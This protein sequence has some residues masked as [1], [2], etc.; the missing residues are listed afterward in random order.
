M[1]FVNVDRDTNAPRNYDS[2]AG[3]IL[4]ENKILKQNIQ[5]IS[6]TFANNQAGYNSRGPNASIVE[7]EHCSWFNPILI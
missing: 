2:G 1:I 5:L 3:D 7:P 6:A 4:L